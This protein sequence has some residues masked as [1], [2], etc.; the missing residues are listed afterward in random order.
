MLEA[1]KNFPAQ[2]KYQPKIINKN[3][4]KSAK[5]FVVLGMGGSHLA[6]DVLSGAQPQLKILIHKNYGLPNLDDKEL[7][8][9]MIIASSYSGNTEE[10]I[11]G[12]KKAINKKLNVVA[13]ATGGRLIALA[14]KYKRPYIELP[15]TGIQ[16]R[17]A[18]GFN[19]RGLLKIMGQ[20][21][22]LKETEIVSKLKSTNYQGRGQ[23]LAKLLKNHVPII[24]SSEANWPLAY[25]WKI[26]FNETGKIPA[27]YNILPELNHNEMTGFDVVEKN[28]QL[29][30]KFSFIFLNDRDDHPQNIKRLQILGKLYKKRK[31]LVIN[32]TLNNK[33]R[34][35]KISTNLLVADWAAYYTALSYGRD[36][37][38]VPMVEEFKKM[39]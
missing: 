18:L 5:K 21:K 36:P 1:I 24:Y 19:L 22:I 14:K 12:F 16:P 25:N 37:E 17:S 15:K 11:D 26:K 3:K 29:S 27:F 13:I 23:K 35:L 33:N 38:P 31:L 39:I 6:A 7:K 32:I 4:Y 34:W 2:F 20:N 9:S 28:R 30:N 10:V 8:E